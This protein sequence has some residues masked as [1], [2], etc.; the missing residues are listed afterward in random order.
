MTGAVISDTVG[1]YTAQ[2]LTIGNTYEISWWVLEGTVAS[3][4]YTITDSGSTGFFNATTTTLTNNV[5]WNLPSN[6]TQHEFLVYL[7]DSSG[8]WEGENSVYFT[9]SLPEIIVTNVTNYNS[10]T[11]S[12]NQVYFEYR[13]LSVGDDYGVDMEVYYVPN[14]PNFMNLSLHDS[15]SYLNFTATNSTLYGYF[16]FTTPSVSGWYC[17]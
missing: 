13:N 14:Y 15:Q 10:S 5:Y 6:S 12:S 9:P 4:N 16:S 17:L 11:S 8:F 3:G 2:N 7:Y 1:T